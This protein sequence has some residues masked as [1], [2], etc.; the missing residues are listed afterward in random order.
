[1][2]VL[3][4]PTYSS[5]YL[6]TGSNGLYFQD[7]DTI[8]LPACPGDD[9][10]FSCPP[11]TVSLTAT[12]IGHNGTSASISFNVANAE[13]LFQSNNA[14][15]NDLAGIDTG[16]FD[17]VL[18]FCFCRPTFLVHA[19]QSLCQRRYSGWSCWSCCRF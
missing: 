17:W 15:F 19:D 5:V 2:T 3:Q 14:A 1:S 8:S 13:A 11:A 4:G 9:S 12:T 7:S 18:P 10:D 6:D 16:N